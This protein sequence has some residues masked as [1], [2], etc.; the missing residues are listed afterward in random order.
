MFSKS[1]SFN[2]K[3]CRQGQNVIGVSTKNNDIMIEDG[4]RNPTIPHTCSTALSRQG[5][6]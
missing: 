1:L 3:E 5:A 6:L 2:G 4:K